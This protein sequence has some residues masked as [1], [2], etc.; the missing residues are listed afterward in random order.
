MSRKFKNYVIKGQEYIDRKTGKTIPSPSVWHSVNDSLPEPPINDIACLYY[1]KIENS[2]KI[3]MLAYTGNGEW[4]DT[5]GKEYKG[6]EVWLEYMP[7]E[8]PIVEKKFFLNEE[9]LKMI[10]SD[11]MQKSEGITVDSKN[12]HFK[13]GRRTVGCGINEHEESLFI[14]CDVVA[15]EEEK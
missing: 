3:I 7:K 11:Y 13:V 6:V 4:S 15:I 2:E 14:G 1:V 9:F 10:V 12:I 8:N 5:E